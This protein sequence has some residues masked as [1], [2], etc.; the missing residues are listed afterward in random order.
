[1]IFK[2]FT[3]YDSKAKAHLPPWI[4]AEVGQAIRIFA[5]MVNDKEHAIGRHPADYTLMKIGAWTDSDANLITDKHHTNL[6]N[7]QTLVLDLDLRGGNQPE[8]NLEEDSRG[9][10]AAERLS[11]A[12][13]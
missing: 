6:A 7:G 10:I 8:L 4:Q 9:L 12:P 5:D 2:I 13:E 1:M 11:A 3:V